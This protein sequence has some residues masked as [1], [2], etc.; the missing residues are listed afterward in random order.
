MI[1]TSINE[2]REKATKML[3]SHEPILIVKSG[4]VTGIYFPYPTQTIPVEFKRELFDLI[5]Q[6]IGSQLKEN[7]ITEEELLEGFAEPIGIPLSKTFRKV[8]DKKARKT[9]RRR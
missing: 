3:H 9:R 1:I 2:F 6:E 7:G 4:E 5:T 8:R